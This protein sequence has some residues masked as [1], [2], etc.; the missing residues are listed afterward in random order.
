MLDLKRTALVR[1]AAF[2]S[3][4]VL[5]FAWPT[6]VSAAVEVANL[7][8]VTYV[9]HAG[10]PNVY[11]AEFPAVAGGG[12]LHLRSQGISTAV[13]HLNGMQVVAPSAFN[14]TVVALD[15]PVALDTDNVVKVKLE[16]IP[17]SSLTVS[18]TQTLEADGAGVVGPAGGTVEIEDVASPASGA[19][20]QVPAGALGKAVVIRMSHA[21]SAPDF[22][23]GESGLSPMRLEP[24]GLTFAVPAI[25]EVPYDPAQLPA[26]AS[27]GEETLSLF[28]YDSGAEAWLSVPRQ[29]VDTRTHRV[30]GA[31]VAH[32]SYFALRDDRLRPAPSG[33]LSPKRQLPVLLV[34]G[35]QVKFLDSALKRNLQCGYGAADVE[36]ERSRTFGY[37]PRLLRESL[38]VDVFELQYDAGRPIS[39]AA[40]SVKRAVEKIMT[41]Y[42]VSPPAVTVIA[43]SMGGLVSRYAIDRAFSPDAPGS[44][45]VPISTLVTLATPH[46]GTAWANLVDDPRF[47]IKHGTC[48]SA[49][50]MAVGSEFLEGEAGLN[51]VARANPTLLS[52]EGPGYRLYIG[53][54]D[55]VVTPLASGLGYSWYGGPAAVLTQAG[56]ATKVVMPGG[57]SDDGSGVCDHA[58]EVGEDGIARI[59]STGHAMWPELLGI[60]GTQLWHERDRVAYQIMPDSKIVERMRITDRTVAI[61]TE[62]MLAQGYPGA[63]RQGEFVV[64]TRQAS[65][66]EEV[67]YD[68]YYERGDAFPTNLDLVFAWKADGTGYVG[69]LGPD[70]VSLAAVVDGWARFPF[71]DRFVG[72]FLESQAFRVELRNLVAAGYARGITV[73]DL[74]QNYY[75]FLGGFEQEIYHRFDKPIFRLGSAIYVQGIP[76]SYIPQVMPWWNP[77]D[78]WATGS[79]SR[80][81]N[82]DVSGFEAS[83]AMAVANCD[84]ANWSSISINGQEVVS[85]HHCCE[86]FWRRTGLNIGSVSLATHTFWSQGAPHFNAAILADEV[87]YRDLTQSPPGG[88]SNNRPPLLSKLPPK[89]WTSE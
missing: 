3:V 78:M 63:S 61:D 29:S 26:D 8:P 67:P 36:D 88:M 4:L 51:T 58:G 39:E 49:L 70:D 10:P 27:L 5:V 28:S 52:G 22:P 30:T 12:V 71:T 2:V 53:A 20:L 17:G 66:F 42:A 55:L 44:G 37:L 69:T 84:N 41:A 32:F 43:H 81:F 73:A 56:L 50:Q 86:N 77:F 89:T 54:D 76:A 85:N 57:C 34:H 35:F 82:L 31:G 16:G 75:P 33:P 15:L 14:Q 79:A 18:V 7:G 87:I 40:D 64:Y 11:T 38:E 1:R 83:Y 74:Q 68:G 24:S 19:T 62:R 65:V 80:S 59:M 13:L 9:R 72:T 45:R 23:D 21:P 25:L 46:L 6:L 60:V 47:P 48:E